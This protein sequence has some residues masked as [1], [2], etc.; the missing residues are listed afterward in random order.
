MFNNLIEWSARNRFIVAVMAVI[1]VVFG[2]Y[3]CGQSEMDVLP[4][5]APPEILIETDAPGLVA[6]EVESLVSFPLETAIN[7]TPG[8]TMVRSVSQTG[9]SLVT[10]IFKYGTDIYT[11]RQLVNEKIQLVMPRLPKTV[12][13]PIMLPVMSAIADTLKIGLVSDSVSPMELRTIAEWDI[14]NRLLAVPGVAR[15]FVMGGDQKQYQVLVDPEKLKSFG[16]TLDQVRSAVE[17]SNVAAPGGYMLTADEQVPI[18][19][20]GRVRDLSDIG[21]SVVDSRNG[22]P[23]LIRHVAEVKIGPAFKIGDAIIN[24]KPGVEVVISRQPWANTLEVT[25]K[26]ESALQELKAGL[27]QGVQVVTLFRQAN[28]IEQSID[29][30]L[31]AMATGGALV[32]IVLLIF[33]ANWRTALISLTAIP[34]SLLSAI[35]VLKATGGSIN[36]MSLGGLAIAVGEVVDDAIVDVENVYRRLREWKNSPDGRSALRVIV[37]SCKEVRSAVVYATF[38]VALVFLP[39]FC[40]TGT[41]GRIFT[42]LAVSYVLATL[43]SLLVALTVTPAMCALLLRNQ[44]VVARSDA[45]LLAAVKSGYSRLLNA[46]MKTPTIVALSAAVLFVLALAVVPLMGQSFLPEFKDDALI[47]SITGLPGQNLSATTRMGAAFEKELLG[48]GD[49]VAIGERAGRA[50]LD[51][52]AAGP[53]FSEF[54][55]QLKDFGRSIGNS[56]ADIREHLNQL[57]GFQYSVQSFINHR[58]DD[59]LTGGIRAQIAVKI[60]GPDLPTLR[61]IAAR[62]AREMKA[63]KGAVDVRTEPLV[64]NPELTIKI[65]RQRA[66]RFGIKSEDL[67]RNLETAFN[68]AVVSQVLEGQKLFGLKIWLKE[69]SRHDVEDIRDLLVDTATGALVPLSEVADVSITQSPNAVVREN[70][71]RRLVVQADTQGR[72]VVGVVNDIKSRLSKLQLPEGYYLVYAGEY[73]AQQE[74]SRRLLLTSLLALIGI[75]ILLRQGLKS[76]RATLLIAANLP[77][78]TIGGILAVVLT[79]NVLSIGSLIG[80]ISLFG[81][82]TRNSLLLVT[83][84]NQL[85]ERGESLRDAVYHGCMGR[86]SPVLMTAITAALGMLPLAMLAGSGRELEQPLAVVIVGGLVTSTALTLIVIPALFLLFGPVPDRVRKDDAQP[87]TSLH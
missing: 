53:Q 14:R 33:L 52:D 9:V 67:S 23:V 4:E 17:K 66:A 63:V 41:E 55:V 15:V 31:L 75:L 8:V 24:G 40:L 10:V 42:P 70:T 54:D 50:E 34:L 26:L 44:Q 62:V 60:F 30:V 69:E 78:A 16:V 81:I 68:G 47:V 74:A 29:N 36:A 61:S 5:F 35:L 6:E 84:I 71:A 64:V 37:D 39:V 57:P 51:D 77:F 28:F 43:A 18:H 20:L 79:G 45:R 58:M 1:L 21:N 85:L 72:D 27:P 76:W 86:V 46:V 25:H 19:G 56:L 12:Q 80:F 2:I 83:Y 32:V 11:A 3:K 22:V 65:D 7:G 59:V 87:A 73:A 49:I 13:S 48:H 82:S 38:I